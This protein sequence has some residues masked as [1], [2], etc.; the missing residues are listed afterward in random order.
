MEPMDFSELYMQYR[1]TDRD[2]ALLHYR[3]QNHK[4]YE[5]E[6]FLPTKGAME[7]AWKEWRS[8]K[9]R[10]ESLEEPDQVFALVKNH[11]RDF[12]D[13]LEFSLQDT[14]KNPEGILL[15]FQYELQGV[16]R[17]DRRNDGERCVALTRRLDLF[18]EHQRTLLGL[19]K[20]KKTAKEQGGLSRSLRRAKLDME[21]EAGK[22]REYFPGFTEEQ[23]K[24]LK[25]AIDGFC[26]QLEEMASSL[27]AEEVSQEELLRD[28]LSRTVKMEPEAYRRLLKKQ[29]GVS[30]EELLSWYKEEM[31]KTR[32]E[33]FKIASELDIPEEAPR[34]MQEVSDV[35]FRYAG[36]CGSA[37]EMYARAAG[38]L[39]R[40]RAIAHE[41]V[42][43][44]EDES[45]RCVP[46]PECYKDSYPWGGYEG[47][48][49]SVRPFRGQMFL[50]QY[51]YQ[52]I[53]DGW[54]KMNTMHEAYPGHHVQYVR[55]ATDTTPETVKIG[56]KQVPIGEG[57]CLRTERAFTFIFAED[58]FFPLF[59]AFR[60]HHTSVRVYVDLMLY[61]F[62]AT[63]EEAVQ[64]Y[65]KELGFD[66][67]TARAQV[68]AHQNSPGY[69]T[70]YYYG[71]KKICDWEQ[72]YGYTK[73]DYTELL[74][75]AGS[76]SMETLGRL[77]KLSPEDRSRYYTKFA[78]L[79][80]EPAKQVE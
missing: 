8:L 54:I 66:R 71:M 60:R 34:T 2:C 17:C 32:A 50:N 49:F 42:R 76:V 69:F 35:L 57:T 62:G 44:P 70:C 73:W 30:L 39:K 9:D 3:L 65:E 36:P 80:M 23:Q 45:C 14:E 47:G 48:D 22:L 55:A 21:R 72:A 6:L 33:V 37:E 38:Y 20:E 24:S 52:N 79:L 56:A 43:L 67:V 51:N 13:S 25:T 75:A 19:M 26:L 46:L 40:T 74:F 53:T 28:D 16:I 61:Y 27:S 78:S 59:V 7:T 63:L 15:G 64:I 29:L 11:L 77:V 31:E 5:K 68:Q 58:P 1:E 10:V 4:P 12:L 41:Y 18:R